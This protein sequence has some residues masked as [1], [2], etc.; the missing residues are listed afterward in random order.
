MRYYLIL[1]QTVTNSRKSIIDISLYPTQLFYQQSFY[2]NELFMIS[3]NY[4]QTSKTCFNLYG[5]KLVLLLLDT[6]TV[7]E[8]KHSTRTS[9]DVIMPKCI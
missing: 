6:N 2:L 7:E 5:A 9:D 4:L 1:V 8:K 3:L